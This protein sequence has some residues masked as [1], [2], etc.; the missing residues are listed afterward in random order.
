M[1]EIN[2]DEVREELEKKNLYDIQKDLTSS[3]RLRTAIMSLLTT[4]L[5]LTI[6]YGMLEDP[7][8][9][10]LSNIGNFF[11]YKIYFII[12]SVV[13]GL[14]IQ[15]TVGVL[16][17]LEE[18]KSKFGYHFI[19]I[20]VALLILTALI[21]A[22]KD[23]YPFWHTVHTVTSGLHALFLYLAL[24][25]FS[26]WVSKENPRLR[27]TIFIWLG[28]V[29]AGSILMII[30]FRHSAL[31]ELWYFITN[32]IFLLYLS[33]VLFE[34]EIIKKSVKL[35]INEDNLNVAIEK[36]F[37]NLENLTEKKKGKVKT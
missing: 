7:L 24:V 9:Y 20:S 2:Y 36:V 19:G 26:I 3:R 16:F 14:S 1:I 4:A 29:W 18:Y 11:D 8:V 6:A 13:A 10:T 21:P 33:L 12:W 17:K 32:I 28:I 30:L 37:V 22:L 15:F 31:F 35:M 27:L 25:P 5:L 34:K 23:I